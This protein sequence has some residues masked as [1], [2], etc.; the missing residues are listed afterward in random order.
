MTHHKIP[1]K[2]LSEKL[3]D[4]T[5]PFVFL[6][7]AL[8]NQSN[9]K[10][11]LFEGFKEIVTFEPKNNLRE[12]FRK[13]QYYH[14]KGYWLCG[15]LAYELGYFLEPSLSGLKKKIDY[16]LAWI[17]VCE[18]PIE[19]RCQREIKNSSLPD[20]FYEA[21]SIQPLIKKGQ[22]KKAIQKIKCYLEE[23]QTYQVNYTFKAQARFKGNPL[24]LYFDLRKT[25]PTHYTA[26]INTGDF[27]FLSFSPE[28]FFKIKNNKIISQPMKGTSARGFDSKEDKKSKKE[29]SKSKKIRAENIMI[30]D[31]LRNDLGRISEKVLTPSL[32]DIEKHKT[33]YQMT[34]TIEAKL[35]KGLTIKDIIKALFPCGSVTGAPKIKTMQIIGELEPSWRGI[36]TGS[37]GYVAPNK[38]SCFNVAIRT[39]EINK[40]KEVNLGV[41]GGIIHDSDWQD[42]YSEALLKADFFS[43]ATRKISLIETLRWEQDKGFWLLDLHLQR[44]KKSAAYFSIPLNIKE[45]KNHLNNSVKPEKDILKIRLTLDFKGKVKITR[46]KIKKIKDPVKIKI[47]KKKVNSQDKFLYH[48]TTRR[49]F[50]DRQLKKVQKKGFF[51]IIFTNEKGQLTEGTFTNLFIK[52]GNIFYTPKLSCGLLPGVLRQYL[53]ESGKAKEKILFLKDLKE[54]EKLFVGNSVRGLLEVCCKAVST[55]GVEK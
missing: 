14:E 36:Y 8:P 12:F 10:S 17:G 25:Q 35:K 44:L 16:P 6:E 51:E 2:Y 20:I 15:Y 39:V 33:L 54:A 28:L 49:R 55:S 53:I 46:E 9:N 21:G 40:N 50:Y 48:K 45:V 47:S 18:K 30:V 52:K 3:F 22:Y 5:A 23:G 32:F 13:I 41:G 1:Q 11:F 38:N 4:L 24:G 31:L 37:I 7:S 34:S 27:K 19:F 42:E 29:L 43:Q 26:F